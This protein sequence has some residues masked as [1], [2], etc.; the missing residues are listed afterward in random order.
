[1]GFTASADRNFLEVGTTKVVS[2]FGGDDVYI[3]DDTPL[4]AG[5]S[6]IISDV[7]GANIL[8]LLNGLSISSSVV[9]NT[10]ARL[11]LS[12]GATVQINGADKFS[13]QL[14]DAAGLSSGANA[15]KQTFAEFVTQT[16]K[17]TSVP[18]TASPVTGGVV[19]IGSTGTTPT[20]SVTGATA[21]VE[22]GS[23][24][25]TVTLSAAQT[26][27][28]TVAYALT[29]SGGAIMGTDAGS[30]TPSQNA[31]TLTF[32]AG[33]TTKSVTVPIITDQVT[34]ETGEGVTITLSSPSTGTALAV[35]SATTA[36]TDVPPSLYT[37]V[38]NVPTVLEGAAAVFTATRTG[39]ISAAKTLTFTTVG[40]TSSTG[41]A[42]TVGVDSTPASGTLTFAAGSNTATFSVNT[43]NDNTFESVEG[44]KVS[45]FDG[46]TSVGTSTI[47]LIADAATYAITAA[48]SNVDEGGT[49]K[50]NVT[51]NV[52][53]G[54]VGYTISGTGITAADA[55]GGLTGTATIT[56]GVATISVP[57]SADKIT[58]GTETLRVTLAD[59]ITSATI[60]IN[61]TSVNE[62]PVFVSADTAFSVAE[63]GTAV[64][65]ATAT[66]AT[67][68][69][70]SISG[71]DS[72]KFSVDSAT[73][74][75]AFK[76]APN[77]EVD[78]KSYALTVTASDGALSASKNIT[79][80]VTDVNE[81]P[82]F[83][84]ATATASYA[85]NG[86]AEVGTYTATDVDAGD[87]LTYSVSGADAA[88]FSVSSTGALSFKATPNFETPASAAGTNVYSVNVIATD[89]G[90]LTATQAVTVTVTDVNEH[91]TS[92][93]AASTSAAENQTTVGT[94]TTTDVD[95]GQTATLTYALGG[96][97][98][99]LF[100]LNT[101]T[102]V[103]SFKAAPNFE[104][105]ASK[106]GTNA[107][108]VTITATDALGLSTTTP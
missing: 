80:A 39:D 75:I 61:D 66:D 55:T 37:L 47:L 50:F 43:V 103:L 58:E 81:A 101:T 102:A 83:A 95:A 77:F 106:A 87:S 23:A 94:Y 107:Y 28:T 49:A 35:A 72:A 15:V 42:A 86:T 38:A 62:A 84:A 9:T 59:G 70:Y 71:T 8:R 21:A 67:A 78:A 29:G 90:S 41:A 82:T 7:D 52:A 19:I 25:F 92:V 44:L 10:V 14:V 76:T 79:V 65:T 30:S 96:D 20:F 32:A 33:E 46:N 69:T 85:E 4:A 100:D 53:D 16:L 2:A 40:D 88:L 31:G 68:L 105:P 17:F 89:K 22:G 48:S 13:F 98:A 34:P 93:A 36:I 24:T 12:N 11:I 56:A 1:M 57:I 74:A 54:T 26:T 91:P 99:A 60:A 97:D 5:Q 51:T 64:T 3:L 73:G 63:N 104:A 108:S 27:A 45:L 18:T 6:I